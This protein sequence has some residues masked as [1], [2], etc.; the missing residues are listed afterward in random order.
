MDR[1][2]VAAGPLRLEGRREVHERGDED[3]VR[4]ERARI[5]G[6]RWSW[7][8]RGSSPGRSRA[9]RPGELP[10]SKPAIGTPWRSPPRRTVPAGNVAAICGPRRSPGRDDRLAA[11]GEGVDHHRR[12]PEDVDHHR[13]AALEGAGGIRAGRRWTWIRAVRASRRARPRRPSR[14]GRAIMARGGRAGTPP[15]FRSRDSGIPGRPRQLPDSRS[16]GAF[17]PRSPLRLHPPARS[18]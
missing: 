3:A 6:C 10:R 13:H 8:S 12:R 9:C 16:I 7:S 14:S 2:L 4:L 11:G 5:A 15:G 18:G 17:D 1:P